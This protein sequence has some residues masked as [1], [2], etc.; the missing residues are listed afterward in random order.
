[1]TAGS[2]TSETSA[3]L[4]PRQ[5]AVTNEKGMADMCSWDCPNCGAC[6][7]DV[8]TLKTPGFTG[9]PIYVMNYSCCGYQDVDASADNIDAAR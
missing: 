3:F 8:E 1:M 6:D 2:P 7:P 9:A 4:W 5:E